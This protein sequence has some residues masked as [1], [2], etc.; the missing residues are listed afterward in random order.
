LPEGTFGWYFL[1]M[2]FSRD[3]MTP[4]E[5]LQIVLEGGTPDRVPVAPFVHYFAA[6]YAGYTQAD[7][8]ENHR[9]YRE[10]M[11]ITFQDLGPWD[12]SFFMD[13]H[14]PI[15]MSFLIP[16]KARLPGRDLPR[17]S[18]LQLV[19][20]EIMRQEDYDWLINQPCRRNWAL[21]GLFLRKLAYRIHEPLGRTPAGRIRIGREVA[22]NVLYNLLDIRMWKQWGI[23][24][25]YG[26]GLEAPF[27][28]FSLARSLTCFSI[29]VLREPDRIRDAAEKLVPGFMIVAKA[30]CRFTR[31]PRFVIMLHRSSNDFVSP[32]QFEAL[33]LPSLKKICLSLISAGIV[34]IL[35]CDGN[36]DKNLDFFLELPEKRLCLQFDG[37]TD[38][39]RAAK[40]LDGHCTLFGDVPA[41]MLV[42][43]SP[44][45]VDQYCRR[46]IEEVGRD[47]AYILGAGCEIPSDAKPEN[48][49]TMIR[50]AEKY[51]YYD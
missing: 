19:E 25:F 37:R 11:R 26:L 12:S 32:R 34:P 9:A 5:R 21:Y 43:S 33:A 44:E 17:N 39:F 46:L 40:L 45:E 31:V 8:W 47:G 23:P 22:Q 6:R 51:G 41:S 16:M 49:W 38:I 14:G 13:S 24:A 27:D 4:G 15:A 18:P 1:A 29:D 35:H 3:R 48:V 2:L 30:G 42:L 20:E 28:T 50:A 7:L 36:W 10:S